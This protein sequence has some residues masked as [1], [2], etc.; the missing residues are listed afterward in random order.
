M[1]GY[2]PKQAERLKHRIEFEVAKAED[3]VTRLRNLVPDA[4][5]GQFTA[6]LNL[7]SCLDEVRSVGYGLA[8]TVDRRTR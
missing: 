1:I 3:A 5:P 7:D 8:E 2:T 6:Q 4:D